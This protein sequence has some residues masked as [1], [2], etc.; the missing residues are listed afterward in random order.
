MVAFCVR[1]CYALAGD[2]AGVSV[3]AGAVCMALY[4]LQCVFDRLRMFRGAVWLPTALY[5]ALW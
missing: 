4:G 3:D 2:P 5:M 1:R